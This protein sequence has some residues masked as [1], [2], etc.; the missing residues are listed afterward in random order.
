MLRAVLVVAALGAVAA[1][2]DGRAHGRAPTLRIRGGG[3]ADV[4]RAQAPLKR[5]NAFKIAVRIPTMQREDIR[6]VH[7]IGAS[8][9]DIATK[10][11]PAPHIFI[12]TGDVPKLLQEGTEIV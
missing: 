12:R 7:A 4:G 11:L 10:N 8:L 5:A 3:L 6:L 2:P 1:G 9:I